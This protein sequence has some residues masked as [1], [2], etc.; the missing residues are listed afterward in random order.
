MFAMFRQPPQKPHVTVRIVTDWDDRE[1][2]FQT[3]T[4]WLPTPVPERLVLLLPTD[5]DDYG[6]LGTWADLQKVADQVEEEMSVSVARLMWTGPMPANMEAIG[7]GA[8]Y[9]IDEGAWL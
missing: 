4:N 3:N 9:L 7:F 1:G 6:W 8:Q 5:H 2:V